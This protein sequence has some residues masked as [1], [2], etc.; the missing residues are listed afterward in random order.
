MD[1][2]SQFLNWRTEAERRITFEADWDNAPSGS[3][4]SQVGL[5]APSATEILYGLR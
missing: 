5:G 1:A 3:S 2:L 4:G